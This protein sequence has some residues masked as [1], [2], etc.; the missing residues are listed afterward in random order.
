MEDAVEYYVHR[1]EEPGVTRNDSLVFI[2]D[3]DEVEG[4][5]IKTYSK[6]RLKFRPPFTYLFPFPGIRN[7]QI[8]VND[9]LYTKAFQLDYLEGTVRFSRSFPHGT[10]IKGT[11]N[12]D[13]ISV[14]DEDIDQ[15]QGVM[16]IAPIPTAQS[17][18]NVAR[19]LTH[20]MVEPDDYTLRWHPAVPA[21]T[22]YFYKVYYLN[23]KGAIQQLGIERMFQ[24]SN[25]VVG[26]TLDLSETFNPPSF[27]MHNFYTDIKA[28]LDIAVKPLGVRHYHGRIQLINNNPCVHL[29]WSPPLLVTRDFMG[30]LRTKDQNNIDSRPQPFVG[31]ISVPSVIESIIIKRRKAFGLGDLQ[32]PLL[33]DDSDIIASLEP[34][35]TM[36]MDDTAEENS[37]YNYS[38][39]VVSTKGKISESA[40]LTIS[41][42]VIHKPDAT[43]LRIQEIKQRIQS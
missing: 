9:V 37:F 8:Y 43:N 21:K 1:S 30:Q 39:W 35:V 23:T 26:Y 17:N 41:T 28:I 24:V 16:R 10:V 20:G 6:K 14:Y 40:K 31:K 42:E 12:L 7:V 29:M 4:S 38:I 3:N 22:N 32:F 5:E 33:N 34:H 11:Y 13:M 27:Y 2:V 15:P 18:P 19:N 36:F 25:K